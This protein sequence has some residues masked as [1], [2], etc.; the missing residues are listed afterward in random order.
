MA[1]FK[2][3]GQL[4]Y[5]K[6]EGFGN[7]GLATRMLSRK[8]D[9]MNMQQQIALQLRE[10]KKRNPLDDIIGKWPGEETDEE[11]EKMLKDLD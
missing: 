11:F 4:S 1:H 10:G 6:M 3:G 2:P 7:A 5:V 8:P 9:K